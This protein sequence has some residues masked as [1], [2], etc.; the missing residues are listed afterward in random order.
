M[1]TNIVCTYIVYTYIVYTC[2]HVNMCACVHV[3]T[4][5]GLQTYM[6][7]P[8]RAGSGPSTPT[9]VR[10]LAPVAPLVV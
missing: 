10:Q 9:H 6:C 7:T 2:I 4:Y 8:S 3:H 1:Y 5:T